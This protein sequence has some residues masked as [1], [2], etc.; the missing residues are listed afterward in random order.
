MLA[1]WAGAAVVGSTGVH[2]RSAMMAPAR[3]PARPASTKT[4]AAP[5]LWASAPAAAVPAEVEEHAD[6]GQGGGERAYRR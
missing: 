3:A 5:A 6:G 1:G 4:A 2:D